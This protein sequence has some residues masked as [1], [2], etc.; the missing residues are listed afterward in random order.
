MISIITL[1]FNNPEEL[2]STLLSIPR[3]DFI[4]SV[5]I[6]GGTSEKTNDYLKDYHGRVVNEKD[7]G[8]A[9]AFNKGIKNSSGEFTMFLNSGDILFNQSYIEKANDI[10][11]KNENIDFVHSNILFKDLTGA[12]IIMKPTFS[13]LG[14]GMPYLHPTMIVRRK[15]FDEI[16]LFNL[17]YKIAM[18]FDLIVRMQKK[19][20]K[21]YYIDE[22]PVVIMEGSGKSAI[23]EW[24]AI[25]ECFK[26][27]KSNKLLSI[28]NIIG[29]KVRISLY[30]LRRI[31]IVFGM[32]DVLRKLKEKKYS[33]D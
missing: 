19:N 22:G 14:R 2:K 32:K 30:L 31:L 8:I 12:E 10:L 13:S 4:E 6:N 7:S 20:L 26:S 27:L 9:D 1:T 28:K 23:D 17:D 29:L 3:K 5:I 15:I 18:D 11:L 16:G 33:N 21:G 24:K 25:K